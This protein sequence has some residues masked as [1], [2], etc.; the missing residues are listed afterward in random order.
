MSRRPPRLPLLPIFLCAMSTLIPTFLSH[1]LLIG[2]ARAQVNAPNCTNETFF[3]TFNSLQQSPC[4][5]ADNLI[6]ACIN[7][8]YVIPALN[9]TVYVGPVNPSNG[10][11]CLCNTVSYNLMS[12]CDACQ[13]ASWITYSVWSTNCTA[14]ATA[15][16]FPKPIPAGTRVPQWAY[17]NSTIGDSWNMTLAQLVG[18]SPEVTGTSSTSTSTAM[19]STS[20]SSHSTSSS[21]P[22]TLS[23]SPS[24][25]SSSISTPH[26]TSKPRVNAGDVVG[27]I[28]G[29]ALIAG[30]VLWFVFRRQRARSDMGEKE[31]PPLQ[32]F[33]EGVPRLYD[34]SDPTTFPSREF[35]PLRLG[36][37]TSSTQPSDYGYS[38]LPEV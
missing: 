1:L 22:S 32:P 27:G 2:S 20:A 37:T 24:T 28:V 34:P 13:G 23:S 8:S 7:E 18:D 4:L 30:I 9:G 36:S 33:A 11:L 17:N 12:A 31:L 15:G 3:W 5:V 16:T 21:S 26:Q 19:P 35:L 25:L 29:A 14:N 38:G 10:N 6:A